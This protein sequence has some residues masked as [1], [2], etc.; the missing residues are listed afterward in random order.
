MDFTT[1][2]QL[3]KRMNVIKIDPFLQGLVTKWG[4]RGKNINTL[5]QLLLCY[6]SGVK[7]ICIPHA[8]AP[9][10]LINRQY[11]K[12]YMEIEVASEDSRRI[13]AGAGLL[14]NSE[15]LDVYTTYA[16]EHFSKN[17][18]KPF[19]FLA[20]AFIHNPVPATFKDHISKIANHLSLRSQKPTDSGEDIFRTLA[21]LTA[22][23]ILLDVSRNRYPRRGM[24]AS[25]LQ[26]NFSMKYS[27]Q[28]LF[29]DSAG[30]IFEEYK[31][32]CE[33]A[34]VDFYQKYW[35]CERRDKRGNRCF[36]VA[37]GH[38]K[39]HQLKNGK[40]FAAGDFES[41]FKQNELEQK[42]LFIDA[43][44]AEL[45]TL[46]SKFTEMQQLDIL[47]DE[48]KAAALLHQKTL[49][50][51]SHFW[52]SQQTINGPGQGRDPGP[53]T[54]HTTC[55]GC[56]FETPIHAIS[57][58]HILCDRCVENYCEPLSAIS[59]NIREIRI[60]PLCCNGTPWQIPWRLQKK[61]QHAG[62]RILSLDG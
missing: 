25:F 6:Y 55:F 8:L 61:P 4:D 11:R 30:L 62:L 44:S 58:G 16:F 49:E 42:N 13:R 18:S 9:P 43:V 59:P 31:G 34:Q 26:Q 54:S 57:C 7:I 53:L 36:N 41:V 60:C 48:G 52:S 12:L 29:S 1:R 37:T 35:P 22:S 21:P 24:Y 27:R 2:D 32:F 38:Q 15:E 47:G 5:E 19:N 20:T 14:M 17:P 39:G 45:E 10:S 3:T 33:A 50:T 46:L 23:Y 40:I 51:Y 28:L 56:L